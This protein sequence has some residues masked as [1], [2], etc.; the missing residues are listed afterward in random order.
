MAISVEN[1][2]FFPPTRIFNAPAEGVPLGI[3]YRRG[4]EET[5]M[6]GLQGGRKSFKISLVV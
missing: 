3:G 4:S 2:Q 1:R 6:M 5:R